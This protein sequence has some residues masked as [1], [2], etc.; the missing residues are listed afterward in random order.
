MSCLDT[1]I[2]CMSW[3]CFADVVNV[4]SCHVDLINF[5]RRNQH[6]T[7]SSLMCSHAHYEFIT[8]ADEFMKT[9]AV[10]ADG[11]NMEDMLSYDFFEWMMSTSDELA[12][13]GMM[14]T[15]FPAAV[16]EEEEEEAD[17]AKRKRIARIC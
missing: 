7:P 17:I 9:I 12:L 8:N 3:I 4:K 11:R 14:S 6:A 15:A 5:D 16:S 13:N 2:C 1:V 10:W